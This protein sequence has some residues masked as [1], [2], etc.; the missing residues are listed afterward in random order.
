MRRAFPLIT[1]LLCASLGAIAV[2]ASDSYTA[3]LNTPVSITG[4]DSV[5]KKVTNAS[6]TG[7]SEYIPT[8]SVAEWQSFVAHPPAGVTLA[9]CSLTCTWTQRAGPEPWRSIAMTPNGMTLLA[10]TKAGSGIFRSTDGGASWSLARAS[11]GGLYGLG[12]ASDGLTAV[13]GSGSG[14]GAVVS[15]STDGGFNWTT[16]ISRTSSIY[17]Y[18]VALASNGTKAFAAPS[19]NGVRN[20]YISNDGG[21]SWGQYTQGNSHSGAAMSA[22][23]STIIATNA[24]IPI[25]ISRDGGTTWT[26]TE[27]ARA[28]NA[29]DVSANGV[30]MIAPVSNGQLFVSHDNGVSWTAQ[31]PVKAWISATISDDGTRMAA[32]TLNEQIYRSEDGGTTWTVEPVPVKQWQSI[33][34]SSD[35]TKIAAV[36][37]GASGDY[38]YTASCQ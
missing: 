13:F 27:T 3:L 21:A 33:A 23:G 31:G 16:V 17:F 2:Y 38:I 32:A 11:S 12:L 37:T 14:S 5:C 8:T 28:W 35:G 4:P 29:P 25:D 22:D 30:H 10:V 36:A 20:F 6:A 1:L 24:G 15:R 26:T 18:A 19:T 7:L 34:M 9:S